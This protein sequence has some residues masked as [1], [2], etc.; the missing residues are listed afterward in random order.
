MLQFSNAM[1]F[2]HILYTAVAMK[3]RVVKYRTL[4]AMW[5]WCLPYARIV[6]V[7]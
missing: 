2:S 6:H 7:R 1:Y 3:F 5:V 4:M